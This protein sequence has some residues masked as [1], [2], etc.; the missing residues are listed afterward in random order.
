MAGFKCMNCNTLFTTKPVT[1]DQYGHGSDC[2]N[3]G[4]AG[5]AILAN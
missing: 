4:N 3:C 5:D 1:G 2:Y